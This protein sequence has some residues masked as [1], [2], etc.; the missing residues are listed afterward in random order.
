MIAKSVSDLKRSIPPY[1]SFLTPMK[2]NKR[3]KSKKKKVTFESNPCDIWKRRS[4]DDEAPQRRRPNK[5][6]RGGTTR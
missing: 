2:T 1:L 5:R 3:S 4:S 6:A